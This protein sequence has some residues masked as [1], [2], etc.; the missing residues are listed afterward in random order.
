MELEYCLF[1]TA[2]IMNTNDEIDYVVEALPEIVKRFREV[3]PQK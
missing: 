1:S 2:D 3:S